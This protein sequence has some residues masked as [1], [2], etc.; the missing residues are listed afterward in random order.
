MSA[1]IQSE[2]PET[3][4]KELSEHTY[5]FDIGMSCS[6]CSGAVNR[7]LGK[8]SGI[9][10][11]DVNLGAEKALVTAEPNLD[12]DTV[13]EKIKKTGKTVYSGEAD[14]VLTIYKERTPKPAAA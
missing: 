13:Y 1:I 11:Y 4:P 12:Y 7:V 3:T 9:K 5:R 8:L 2:M 6:G 14:G 10:S